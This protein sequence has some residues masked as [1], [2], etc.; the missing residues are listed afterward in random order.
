MAMTDLRQRNHALNL[1]EFHAGALL[2][3]S[4]PTVIF[5]ELTQNCNLNCTMCR[6]AGANS[7][8]LNM[9][10]ELFDEIAQQLFP[11]A[12]VVD[13]RGWGESTVRPDFEKKVQKTIDYGPRIRLVTNALSLRQSTWRLL[14]N[15]GSQVTVSV[16]AV[17]QNTANQLNRGCLVR[18]KKSLEHGANA[19]AAVAA[20]DPTI[21]FNTVVSSQNILEI[22]AIV[23]MATEFGVRRVTLFPVVAPRGSQLH[24]ERKRSV[25]GRVLADA[26]HVAREGNV[27]LR[28]GASLDEEYVNV[29]ALPTRCLHP[30]SYAYISH[31]GAVGYCDHLIGHEALTLERLSGGSFTAIWNNSSFQALRTEHR[32][33]LHQA[34]PVNRIGCG[35]F[36]H[37][38]WCYRRRYVDFEDEIHPTSFERVVG[39]SG[40]DPTEVL[41]EGPFLRDDFLNGGEL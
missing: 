26:A 21:N 11:T 40:H 23:A 18:L 34:T 7:A 32:R 33:H 39:T 13:L 19:A 5:V 8:S 9:E 6:S 16:D 3:E 1:H 17:V 15:F 30:W 14:M 24:I 28:I 10:D 38:N 27:E 22:P 12:M 31:T 4:Y 20:V 36:K 41:I 29:A 25:I 2:L 35:V 37:C